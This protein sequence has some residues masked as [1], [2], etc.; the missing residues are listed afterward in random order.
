VQ[1]FRTAPNART[2]V[3]TRGVLEA[4]DRLVLRISNVIIF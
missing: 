2:G 1:I 4:A 3:P